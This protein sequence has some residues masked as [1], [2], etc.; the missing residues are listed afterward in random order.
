MN[1]NKSSKIEQYHL[2]KVGRG[3]GWAGVE[4]SKGGEGRVE[5]KGGAGVG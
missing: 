2:F 1:N 4:G 5:G 3:W